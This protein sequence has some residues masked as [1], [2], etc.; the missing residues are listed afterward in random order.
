MRFISDLER[1]SHI[2]SC[3]I[4]DSYDISDFHS[5]HFVRGLFAIVCSTIGL[6]FV[7]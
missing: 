3:F 4:L 5:R 6:C 1:N 2:V 7:F